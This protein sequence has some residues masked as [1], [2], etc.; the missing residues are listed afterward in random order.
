MR[1]TL[2]VV[3]R[4]A[5][6]LFGAVATESA[7]TAY[8]RAKGFALDWLSRA[9]EMLERAAA[10]RDARDA[11]RRLVKEMTVVV[12]SLFE[13]LRPEVYDFRFSARK[14]LSRRPDLAAA[15]GVGRKRKAPKP[16]AVPEAQPVAP[17]E[18]RPEPGRR[19]KVVDFVT[20]ARG[21][22][23]AALDRDEVVSMLEPFG[24]SREGIAGLLARVEALSAKEAE[25]EERKREV[26][27]ASETLHEALSALRNWLVPSKKR[28]MTALKGRDDLRK[29]IDA[30]S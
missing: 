22:L 1:S 21:V 5:Q 17:P 23:S 14:A 18:T 7:V 12:R 8:L 10:L 4:V 29:L 19:N 25:H 30:I 11:M 26:L 13:E 20:E 2:F 6:A 9:K 15:L 16:P 24:Y 27:A 3:L 28:L